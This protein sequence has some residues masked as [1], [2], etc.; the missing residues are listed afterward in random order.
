M[1]KAGVRVRLAIDAMSGDR[2]P[3]VAAAAALRALRAY[4]GLEL[5]LVG[6]EAALSGALHQADDRQAERLRVHHTSQVVTMDE[7]VRQALRSK[8]DSS[9][10]VAIDLVKSGEVAACVSAGNTGALMATARYVLK[11]LEGVDRPAICTAVPTRQGRT[12]MLDLGANADCTAG[13]L[14]QFAAMGAALAAAV[15]GVSSPS[16]GLLNIG[17][18]Q[19]KGSERVKKAARVLEASR[20]NYVGYVEGHDIGSGRVDVVVTDGFT[21]NVALKTMEGTARLIA[22]ILREEFTRNLVT[23]A[24]GLIAW[25]TL[26]RVHRRLD[27]QRYNGASFLGLRGI[28]VKSHGSAD[29]VGFATAIRAAMI[30]VEQAVPERINCLLA[31]ALSGGLAA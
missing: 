18:E 10:R 29:E 4:P 24:E 31:E 11:G 14:V 21:G 15:G 2:G 19:I 8:R 3:G 22:T 1:N 7:P 5:V 23:R 6:D 27:P 26:Q 20:L 13:H 25:P 12:Y 16:I 9:M 17:S 30:E 28:V